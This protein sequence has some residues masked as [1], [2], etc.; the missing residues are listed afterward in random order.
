MT[1]DVRRHGTTFCQMTLK[2]IGRRIAASR[3][4]RGMTQEDLA[5]EAEIDRSFLSEIENGHTNL[6]VET[7]RRIAYALRIKPSELLDD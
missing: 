5:G 7:L 2:R 3:K 6:S 1:C 4:K